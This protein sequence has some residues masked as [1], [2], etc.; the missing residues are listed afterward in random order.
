MSRI[1]ELD[2]YDVAEDAMIKGC[3]GVSEEFEEGRRAFLE[4]RKAVFF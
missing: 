1:R 4:K 2:D 3:L